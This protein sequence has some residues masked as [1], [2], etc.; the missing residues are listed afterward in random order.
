MDIRVGV[1]GWSIPKAHA[2]LCPGAG[3]HLARYAQRFNAVEINSSFYRPHRASTYLRWAESVPHAFRF[4]VKLPR[5]I[6]HERKLTGSDDALGRFLSEV[7]HLGP[8]LGPILIQ[9]PPSLK[10]DARIAGSFFDALRHRCAGSVVCEPRHAS[11]FTKTVD[12]FFERRK[13][14][15]VAAD[16]ASV[17][18]ARIPGGYRKL[19]Y[20]RLHGSPRMYYSAYSDDDLQSIAAAIDHESKDAD[21]NWCVFDNTTLGHGVGNAARLVSLIQSVREQS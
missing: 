15:R 7:Q 6:T 19:I 18:A 4:S 8:K 13:I 5:E 20:R 11:W 3:T 14:A 16:P 9:L 2:H 21:E 12:Q 10:F 1:A 17:P